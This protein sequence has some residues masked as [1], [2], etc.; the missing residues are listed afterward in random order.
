MND[1]P[2]IFVV[3]D[4][5][6]WCSRATAPLARDPLRRAYV[7]LRR[8]VSPRAP[9]AALRLHHH[10]SG[11]AGDGR[12]GSAEAPCRHGLP[13]PDDLSLGLGHDPGGRAGRTGWRSAPVADDEASARYRLQA[14]PLRL[15]RPAPACAPTAPAR[16]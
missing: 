4:D 7:L 14:T 12:V 9:S 16:V 11:A 3:D 15:E 5:E 10:A 13:A 2:V 1:R 6:A 8:G